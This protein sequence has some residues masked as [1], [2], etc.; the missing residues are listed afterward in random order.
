MRGGGRC[1][2]CTGACGV[3]CSSAGRS[4]ARRFVLSSRSA[5]VTGQFLHV[6]S[7]AG[8]ET[9]DRSLPLA[10]RTALVTGAARGIGAAI[11]RILAADW[12]ELVVLDVPGA[13]TEL[14][15][16]A[17]ELRAVPIQLDVT[18]RGA[19]RRLVSSLRERGLT[20]DAVVLN[21]GITR[22]KTLANMTPER[23]DPVLAVNI[24]SQ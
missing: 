3:P 24:T 12:A 11:A 20:L 5:F 14:S 4:G 23:W 22:D 7:A 10:G 9:E 1:N 18:S 17:N 2:G 19:G 6:S 15:R 16:L 8:G 21:A 13:G